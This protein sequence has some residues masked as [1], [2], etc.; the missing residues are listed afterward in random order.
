MESSSAYA[1]ANWSFMRTVEDLQREKEMIESRLEEAMA[2]IHAGADSVP[3]LHRLEMRR[4][5][6]VW[7]ISRESH[8]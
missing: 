3:G 8:A 6:L 7:M 4:L 2:K 5:E 1:M